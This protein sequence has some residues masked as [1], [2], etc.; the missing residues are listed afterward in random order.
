MPRYESAALREERSALTTSLRAIYTSADSENRSLTAEETQEAARIEE[1]FK[2]ASTELRQLELVEG[3]SPETRQAKVEPN[4]DTAETRAKADEAEYRDAIVKY[5][6]T[7]DASELRTAF[8]TNVPANGG[9]AVPQTWADNVRDIL[10]DQ[11]AIRKLAT[12]LNTTTGN[13]INFPLVATQMT[14][15]ARAEGGSLNESEDTVKNIQLNSY[16][17]SALIKTSREF[18]R[19]GLNVD[20]WFAKRAGQAIGVKEG[21][22]FAVGA[23]SGS[24]QAQGIMGVAATGK[25]AASAGLLAYTDITGLMG[26]VSGPYRNTPN[27]AFV[28][29]DTTWVALMNLVD[30]TGRPIFVPSLAL[31]SPDTLMGKPLYT[32]PNLAAIGTGNKSVLFGD[33]SAYTIRSVGG[34]EVQVLNELYAAN[35]QVGFWVREYV[36]GNLLDL[37]AAKV[38]LHP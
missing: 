22:Y 9:F 33:I 17:V 2:S 20:T 19:D 31:G 21:N 26:S 37:N 36:D 27:T 14:A 4:G 6:A 7:G 11:G 3:Y 35:G 38:L 15:A 32:D 23:G 18:L 24:S 25:T 30:T 28:V 8:V 29:S 13:P 12:V 34:I 1:R 5:L 16:E 10:V